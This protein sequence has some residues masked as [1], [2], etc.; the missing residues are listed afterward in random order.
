MCTYNGEKHIQEQLD[1]I[2]NNSMNDWRL[3]V[4]DDCSTDNTVEIIQ[5]HACNH[6]ENEISIV[7][8]KTNIG[9][10]YNFLYASQVIGANMKDDDYIMFC[11]Q[12]DIWK[13]DKI[14]KSYESMKELEK[15]HGIDIPLL[16]STDVSLIDE[17]KHLIANSYAKRNRFDVAH[18]DLAYH[19][20]ENH[21]QGCTIMFNKE[22]ANCVKELPK[23]VTMHD[24]WMA[25][26]AYALGHVQYLNIQTMSYRDYSNSVTGHNKSFIE[27]IWGKIIN[28]KK[29]RSIIYSA[30]PMYK[31]CLRILDDRLSKD[32]KDILEAYIGFETNSFFRKRYDIIRLHMWKTGIIRNIGLL[33]LI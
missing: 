27:D 15:S 14:E 4:Y 32:S 1:S 31:E 28:I 16:V 21:V 13:P 25:T 7:R 10:I 9:A 11:D 20:M 22:L 2:A 19:V 30:I 33:F 24:T 5:R 8:N 23:H 6:P 29:Q 26:V 3:F 12:D 17:N 18:A